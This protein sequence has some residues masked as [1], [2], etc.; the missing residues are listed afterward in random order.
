MRMNFKL[1]EL[2]QFN[3]KVIGSEKYH[4]KSDIWIRKNILREN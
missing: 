1:H 4:L 3:V 2:N